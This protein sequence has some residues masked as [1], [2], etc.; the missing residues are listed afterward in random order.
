VPAGATTG[1]LSVIAAGGISTTSSNFTINSVVVP[2]PTLFI[3]LSG[4]N[5]VLSWPTNATGYN[6]QQTAGLN[7]STWTNFV[8]TVNTSGTNKTVTLTTPPGRMFFRL[9]N[10]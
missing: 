2:Q 5:V 3:A 10:P 4:G 8:G 7:P 6:L 9:A 1:P